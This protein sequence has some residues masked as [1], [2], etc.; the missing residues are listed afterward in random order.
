MEPR[1]VYGRGSISSQGDSAELIGIKW[2][3]STFPSSPVRKRNNASNIRLRIRRSR[4]LLIFWSG[5]RARSGL[6][7]VYQSNGEFYFSVVPVGDDEP[8]TFSRGDP[9]PVQVDNI[10]VWRNLRAAIT[11][12]GLNRRRIFI[13]Y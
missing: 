11:D 13:V 4:F 10:R 9:D 7:Y 12:I 8:A 5:Q 6:R 3:R 1:F 2:K